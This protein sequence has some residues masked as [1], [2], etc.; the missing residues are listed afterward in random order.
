MTRIM[1]IAEAIANDRVLSCFRC[2][3]NEGDEC[4]RYPPSPGMTHGLPTIAD[5]SSFCGEYAEL[6]EDD[7]PSDIATDVLNITNINKPPFP[8]AAS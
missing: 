5:D 6:V 4:H 7:G 3:F 8:W 2:T 1:Y